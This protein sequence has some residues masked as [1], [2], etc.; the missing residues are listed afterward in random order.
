LKQ[1]FI[2]NSIEETK[3]FASRFAKKLKPGDIL[4]LYGRL[5]AGKTAFI[6]GLAKGLGFKGK[7]FSPTFI[8]V[9]P[10]NIGNKK[11][12]IEI[13]YHIDLYRLEDEKDLKS[14]G[15]SE[16]LN[17]PNTISVIEWPEKIERNLPKKAIK[18]E[19]EVLGENRRKFSP[20]GTI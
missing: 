10:Y 17:E 7:V 12:K 14:I 19:I 11:A 3:E 20:R 16:F 6:Q 1:E 9:R 15:I 13:L 4:A 8:F 2:S 5:G 18:I